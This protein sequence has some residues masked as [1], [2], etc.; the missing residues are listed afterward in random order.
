MLA[1]IDPNVLVAV[2]AFL[3]ALVTVAIPQFRA[4]RR[5]EKHNRDIK[6]TLGEKNGNGN[7]I[8][9]IERLL[10]NQTEMLGWSQ[11]HDN[12]DDKRFERIDA[13]IEQVSAQVAQA[14]AVAASAAQIAASA[15]TSA[16]TLAEG[17]TNAEKGS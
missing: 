11:A 6:D 5:S 3:T 13:A 8:Q 2:F 12:K 17:V 16:A 9:M 1:A 15:A 14:S 10:G 7:A 4:N